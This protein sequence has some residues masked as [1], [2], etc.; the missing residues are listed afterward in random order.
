M[1]PSTLSLEASY[2]VLPLGSYL[3]S[4]SLGT[5]PHTA[6]MMGMRVYNYQYSTFRVGYLSDLPYL[7]AINNQFTKLNYYGN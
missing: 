5:S 1:R 2:L 4:S 6:P 7:C 3:V